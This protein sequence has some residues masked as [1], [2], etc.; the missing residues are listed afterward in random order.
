M[1]NVFGK[2]TDKIDSTIIYNDTVI[3]NIHEF[4]QIERRNIKTLLNVD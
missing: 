1:R 3:V 2:W 4:H